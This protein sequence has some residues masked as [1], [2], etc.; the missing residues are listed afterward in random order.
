MVLGAQNGALEGS[1]REVESRYALQMEQLNGL[2]LR[3]EA[4]LAQ[5]R[6][7]LQRQADEYQALLNVKSKLEAEIATYRQL[8]DGGEQLRYGAGGAGCWEGGGGSVGLGLR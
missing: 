2:I 5:A 1:L 4:E 6:G 8:L 7:E 3:A